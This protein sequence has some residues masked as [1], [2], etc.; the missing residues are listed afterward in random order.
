MI[1]P[2]NYQLTLVEKHLH[3]DN[4]AEFIFKTNEKAEFN[5]GQFALFDLTPYQ[6]NLKRSYSIAS[7]PHEDLISF[8][9]KKV[10]GG[11]A[12]T[13]IFEKL[14][15][16]TNIEAKLPFGH[17]YLKD[18]TKEKLLVGTGIG[19]SP[20][21]G[22]VRKLEQLE[23]PEK[24]RLFYGVRFQEDLHYASY[25]E[26]LADK[27]PNFKYYQAVS[28]PKDVKSAYVSDLIKTSDIDF[29]AQEAMVCGSPTVARSVKELLLNLGVKEDSVRL[30]AF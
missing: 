16:G 18:E 9:I 6:A 22:I 25:F 7:S 17:F 23:F 14:E 24:T 29:T 3:D 12:T 27:Y 1:I 30:E 19:I 5:A 21:L 13:I 15:I 8:L 11:Q 20:I 4:I 28:R 2:K 26:E 10:K